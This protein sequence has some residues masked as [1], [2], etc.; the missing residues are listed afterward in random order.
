MW[1]SE[2]LGQTPRVMYIG[3][4]FYFLM[5][6]GPTSTLVKGMKVTMSSICE[7]AFKIFAFAI[8]L[9]PNY[10]CVGKEGWRDYCPC[11]HAKELMHREASYLVQSRAAQGLDSVP[12]C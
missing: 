3:F 4:V 8:S 10:N 5:P 2:L 7:A 6:S 11:A 1:T 9:C 12:F